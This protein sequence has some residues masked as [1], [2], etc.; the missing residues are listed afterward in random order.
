MNHSSPPRWAERL[1]ERVLGPGAWDQAALGDLAEAYHRHAA[2]RPKPL[3]DLWYAWQGLS[4]ILHRALRSGGGAGGRDPAAGPPGGGAG[5]GLLPD[6]RWAAGITLRRPLTALGVVLTLGLGLGAN[7]AVVSVMD[8]S[9]RTTSWW[10]DAERT[11]VLWPGHAFS[12][13]QLSIFLDRPSSY[14]TLG[15]YRLESFMVEPPGGD[16][17]SVSGAMISPRLFAELRV[18]PLLG[19]GFRPEEALPGGEQV[20]VVGRSLWLREMGGDAAAIGTRILVNGVARTVVGVQGDGGSAPGHG[21]E[22]WLPLVLDPADPDFF[23]DISYTLVGVLRN[24]ASA[25]EG[26]ADLRAFGTLLSEM[27]PFFYRPDYLQDGTVRVA[28]EHERAML[29]TPL[30]LLMGGTVGLLLVAA[31]NVGN[32]LL[33]RSVER[34]REFAVRRALGAG[35]GRLA[36]QLAIEGALMAAL[37]SFLAIVVASPAAAALARLFPQDLGVAPGGLASPAVALLAS[38]GA[39]L[40]WGVLTGV[41][42]VA[43]LA[44]DARRL[45]TALAGRSTPPRALV[46]LQSCL[47]TTLLI[48]ATLL[49]SSVANLR[50]IPLGFLPERVTTATVSAPDE[51]LANRDRLRRFQQDVVERARRL[52]GATAAGMTSTVPL[53]EL[54]TTTPVNPQGSEV[55]VSV[56]IQAAR[57]AVDAGFFGTMGIRLEAGRLFGSTERG[58]E[59]SA[60]V[61]NRTLA[62]ALWPG[63]DPVGRSISID[64]HAW[65]RFVP[66]VGVVSDFRAES[67]VEPPRPAVFVSLHEWLERETSLVVRSEAAPAVLVPALRAAVREADSAVPVGEV[68]PLSGVVRDA[69]GTSWVTMGLLAALA[70]IATGLAALGVHAVLAHHVTRRRREIG[71]RLALGAD[72]GRLVRRILG[73]GLASTA[74]GVVIGCVVAA[75]AARL[76]ESLLFGVSP[77][78]P[79]AFV[80]PA[81]GVLAVAAAAASAPAARAG[82]LPPA[83]VLREE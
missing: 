4:L 66:V 33:A 55:D 43:C 54:P 13:G 59:P 15:G 72:R 41:P 76:L 37:A 6:L 81:V 48:A 14:E 39:A 28:A 27:F 61:V 79:V 47:A 50:R 46:V 12:R 32:M 25:D 7:V 8:G 71:V 17:R 3:C 68:R 73:S 9:F 24:G 45:P 69:Y 62:E 58:P 57:F 23:P 74:I 20:A 82:R 30:I 78:E 22:L 29:R 51:L 80:L 52:P 60:V 21:S 49:V 63:E 34:G 2:R 75:A 38:A 70:G 77:L 83:E 26:R 42:I 19:R 18:Q 36:R 1:L 44:G 10:A 35:R 40:T 67:L 53:Q 11:V 65:S 5:W 64:P 16:A 31:L 56:A